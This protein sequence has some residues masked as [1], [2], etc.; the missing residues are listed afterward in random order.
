MTLPATVTRNNPGKREKEAAG[1]E[2]WDFL[3]KTVCPLF[4]A[5]TVTVVHNW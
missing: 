2:L 4:E 1:G 5:T 3:D